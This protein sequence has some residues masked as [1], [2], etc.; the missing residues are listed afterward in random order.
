MKVL[1]FQGLRTKPHKALAA[2][3][4]IYDSFSVIVIIHM[5]GSRITCNKPLAMPVWGFLDCME[6]GSSRTG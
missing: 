4:G 6:A 5:A 3:Q 1:H 2:E